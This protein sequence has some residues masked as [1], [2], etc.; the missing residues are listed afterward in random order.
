MKLRTRSGSLRL[1]LTRAEVTA[2]AE[3]GLVEER[4]VFGPGADDA[5]SYALVATDTARAISARFLAGERR[6]VVEMPR[7]T[8]RS[9]AT[10]EEVGFAVTQSTPAGALT[11]LVE[12]DFACLAPRPG[13]DDADT[14]AHPDAGKPGSSC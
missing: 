4:V 1:R 12:K 13:D 5:L 14:F 9:W 10:N 7:A 3:T 6:I 2:L 11:L 8:A